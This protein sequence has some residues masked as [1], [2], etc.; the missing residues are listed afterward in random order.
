M[1][2][3]SCDHEHKHPAISA[4]AWWIYE[5]WRRMISAAKS[6]GESSDRSVQSSALFFTFAVLFKRMAKLPGHFRAWRPTM[7][8]LLTALLLVHRLK[9]PSNHS[10]KSKV[11]SRSRQPCVSETL[12]MKTGF[13]FCV[14][15]Y[16]RRGVEP[17]RGGGDVRPAHCSKPGWWVWR[18][19]Q[20]I[21]KISCPL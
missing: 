19:S 2:R 13:V 5:E 10:L 12:Q 18:R 14:R 9:P 7:K 16:L 3:S 8:R 17:E 20:K 1:D 15:K 21:K 11:L 4:T 6:R